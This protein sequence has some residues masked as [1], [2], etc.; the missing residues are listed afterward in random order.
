MIWEKFFNMPLR[1]KESGDGEGSSGSGNPDVNTSQEDGE[2]GEEDSEEDEESEEK[3]DEEELPE[4]EIK[5]A[6]ALYRMLKDPEQRSQVIRTL[7]KETGLLGTAET[8]KDVKKDT[9]TILDI[10]NEA[11]G[12]K[13][14]FLGPQLAK[15]IETI[16]EQERESQNKSVETLREQHV[17]REVNDAFDRLARETKGESRKFEAKMA[18]LADKVHAGPN[19]DTFEYI[20]YLYSIASAEKA[21]SQAR[22]KMIDKINRNSKDAGSRLQSSTVAGKDIPKQPKGLREAVAMAAR[23]LQEK[24]SKEK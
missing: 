10:F 6:K 16:L 18:Q 23:N 9:K 22:Q 21:G 8:Q 24:G 7:A 15:A 19:L 12:E 20:N 5:E 17:R 11:L 2:E 4:N 14:N 1:D 13:Y 3:E